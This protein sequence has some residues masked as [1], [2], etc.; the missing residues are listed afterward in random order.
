MP[1]TLPKDPAAFL[2]YAWDWSAW[3]SEGETITEFS[4]TPPA[5]LT[6][7]ETTESQG[8]VTAW[9]SGGTAGRYYPLVCQITTSAGRTDE[10]TIILMVEER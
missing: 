10:R 9:V 4:V 5:G 7:E 3:L 8:R 2:D 6:V 1:T